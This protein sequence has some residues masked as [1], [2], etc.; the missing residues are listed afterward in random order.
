MTRG[1]TSGLPANEFARPQLCMPKP[2]RLG[3]CFR[4]GVC[5]LLRNLR[6]PGI[7]AWREG[8]GRH[9]TGKPLD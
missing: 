8:F 1:R 4:P 7:C 6:L 2:A 3:L 9:R 5:G